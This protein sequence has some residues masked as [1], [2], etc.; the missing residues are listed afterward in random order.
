MTSSKSSPP[1]RGDGRARKSGATNQGEGD[2]ESD[3]RFR[4]HT[5][6]FVNSQRGQEA[7]KHA[8][9]VSEKERK[10]IERAEKQAGRHAHEIDFGKK[11]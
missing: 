10:E 11:S 8:G 6:E 2:L 7:A 3:R 9:D 1:H 4:E 5:E